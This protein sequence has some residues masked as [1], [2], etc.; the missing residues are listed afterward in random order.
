VVILQ[1][2]LLLR[3]VCPPCSMWDGAK[4]LVAS[5]AFLLGD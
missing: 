3:Y 2:A 1:W 4:D 5:S